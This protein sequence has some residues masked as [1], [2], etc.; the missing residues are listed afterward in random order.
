MSKS[1]GEGGGT[2][3]STTYGNGALKKF[4]L[5]NKIKEAGEPAKICTAH[6]SKKIK[7]FFSKKIKI[8]IQKI[9]QQIL[10]LSNSV[11]LARAGP[12]CSQNELLFSPCL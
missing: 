10:E 4:E 1:E 8:K 7:I 5:V 6:F 11:L 3:L 9:L 2:E 12:H